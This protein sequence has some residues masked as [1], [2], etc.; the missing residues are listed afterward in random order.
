M[1]PV[2]ALN[3]RGQRTGSAIVVLHAGFFVTGVVTTLLGPLLPILI[4]RW[5]LSDAGAGLFFSLQFCGNLAGIASLGSLLSR[6]GYRATFFLG[7]TFMSLGIALLLPIGR[8][9][10]MVS[11]ALF[12]YGLGLI[13]SATNLWVAEVA[14][15]RR[16]AALSVLN[17]AWGVGAISCPALVMFAQAKHQLL[18]LLF[19]IAGF[20][21]LLALILAASYVEPRAHGS[22]NSGSRGQVSLHSKRA[23]VALGGLFFL[24]VGTEACIGG[25]TAALAKHIVTTPGELW[26]LAPMFFWAGLLSGRAL[27]PF[28][29]ARLS[30]GKMLTSGLLLAT[31]GT[32]ALLE[33]TTFRGAATCIIASGLG[34]AS[35]Y[36]LLVA[37]MVEYYGERARRTGSA[38]FALACLGGATMPLLVGFTSVQARSLRTGLLV[39]VVGCIVMTSLLLPLRHRSVP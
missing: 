24:Y 36:P 39:P 19:G 2:G 16:A 9:V 35:I 13:L 3:E 15:S 29:L 33:V 7:F 1:T 26:A 27:A 12:G 25:W 5:S 20:S 18:T 21:G 17:L 11:T 8:P 34:L 4:A 32:G 30:E 10:G 23:V 22:D 28:V 14:A 31:I 38:M 6:R 37:R